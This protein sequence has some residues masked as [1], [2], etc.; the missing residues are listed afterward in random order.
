MQS[1]SVL[2]WTTTIQFRFVCVGVHWNLDST[3]SINQKSTNLTCKRDVT[4][5]RS[6]RVLVTS[7]DFVCNEWALVLRPWSH[8]KPTTCLQSPVEILQIVFEIWWT[9]TVE[10]SARRLVTAIRAVR[11]SEINKN[12]ANST[13]KCGWLNR[14]DQPFITTSLRGSL[15]SLDWLCQ[16][17]KTVHTAAQASEDYVISLMEIAKRFSPGGSH[18][19]IFHAAEHL[20]NPEQP[21][22]Q[23]TANVWIHHQFVCVGNQ[24]QDI[25]LLANTHIQH[26]CQLDWRSRCGFGSGSVSN[27]FGDLG[28]PFHAERILDIDWKGLYVGRQSY[29]DDGP[30]LGIECFET[31]LFVDANW[32]LQGVEH[33]SWK[34]SSAVG[35]GLFVDWRGESFSE[36]SESFWGRL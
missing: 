5:T 13:I 15:I 8:T 22:W 35:E 36:L 20:P 19:N 2:A 11:A 4:R 28:E 23:T 16:F 32:V 1:W 30:W 31:S 25:G 26:D 29:I 6:S 14:N 24:Q 17:S 7:L 33:L 10:K 34:W 18:S 3:H 27:H 9:L 12:R 21:V